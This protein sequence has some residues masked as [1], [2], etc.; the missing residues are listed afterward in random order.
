LGE[1]KTDSLEDLPVKILIGGDSYWKI[2][3][4][5]P[6]IRIS[7][8]L[9]LIPSIFG[10]ILSGNRS[11]ARVNTTTVNFVLSDR[12]NMPPDDEL[13]RCWD[14]E[15]IGI[16]AG[17]DRAMSAKDSALLGEFHASF[18][19]QG[20]RRVVSLPKKQGIILS[21]NRMNAERRLGHLRMR[22]DNKKDV[23]E[24]YYAQMAD[25]IAKR[26][27]EEAPLEDS[28][29]VFYLPHHALRKKK[30]GKTKWRVVFDASSHERD[31]PSLNDALEMGP[32]F[33]PEI[34]AILLRFRLHHSAIVGDITQAFLQLVLNE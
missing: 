23:R 6:P 14:L 11:G 26:Q 8:S 1:P 17:P 27:V 5:I 29:T 34:L 10:W 2:L 25:Y 15:A 21:N 13:R 4:D 30:R 12:P 7:E 19:M 3:K 16:T 24:I 22:L 20:Q 32:N 33:L 9:V 31:A 28:T 18:R